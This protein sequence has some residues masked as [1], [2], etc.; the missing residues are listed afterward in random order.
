MYSTINDKV[1]HDVVSCLQVRSRQQ[2]CIRH[3]ETGTELLITKFLRNKVPND[4][5]PNNN[6]DT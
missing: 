1:A 3:D 2:Y 5:V 4:T 6:F